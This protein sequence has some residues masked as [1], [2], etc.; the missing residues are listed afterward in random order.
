MVTIGLLLLVFLW[1]IGCY[2]L[3]TDV[4]VVSLDVVGVS[5]LAT[6]ALATLRSGLFAMI[7]V[8]CC[9]CLAYYSCFY[10]VGDIMPPNSLTVAVII[11]SSS[12]LWLG[13]LQWVGK[14]LVEFATLMARVSG[15]Q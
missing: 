10:A 11:V 3:S 4:V 1:W 12:W 14:S 15:I 5:T 7:A 2:C 9:N 6:S 13:T 8:S